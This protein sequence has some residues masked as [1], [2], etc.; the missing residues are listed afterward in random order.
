MKT[1]NTQ[2][3]VFYIGKAFVLLAFFYFGVEGLLHPETFSS[4]IPSFVTSIIPA[5]TVVMIHGAIEI[6][7][8]L[9]ILFRIG[10]A[11]PYILLLI[12]FVG[13]VST[14]SGTTQIRDIAI[15]GGLLL[16]FSIQLKKN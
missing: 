4:F 1:E 8:S 5:T 10:G 6:L 13:V 9:M 15:L 14:V 16:L 3:I 11:I 2:K 12:S 7:L